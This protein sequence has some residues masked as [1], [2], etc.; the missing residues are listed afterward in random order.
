MNVTPQ[1]D[2]IVDEVK[3]T[4]RKLYSVSDSIFRIGDY[5]YQEYYIYNNN[6]SIIYLPSYYFVA[7]LDSVVLDERTALQIEYD[8]VKQRDIDYIKVYKE[9]MGIYID[10]KIPGIEKGVSLPDDP[11][12]E[13]RRIRAASEYPYGDA[14]ER[15]KHIPVTV[16]STVITADD[17]TITVDDDYKI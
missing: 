5:G 6:G 16:D 2:I 14:V 1:E 12:S 11:L 8:A 7:M 13:K 10:G 9:R 17:T 15:D 3:F 4:N